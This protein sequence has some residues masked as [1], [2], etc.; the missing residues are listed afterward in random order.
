[1]YKRQYQD[2][3]KKESQRWDYLVSPNPYSTSIF[4]NAF[5]VS[6]DKILETGYPRNDKLSHKRND[7]CLLY[8]SP[9]PRD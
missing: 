4:Q 6:R 1:M 7:T 9:S 8:T 5:H 2:G 3:F